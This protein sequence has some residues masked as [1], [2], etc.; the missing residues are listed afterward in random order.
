[1]FFKYYPFMLLLNHYASAG[2]DLF[3]L[4]NG[5]N[6]LNAELNNLETFVEE[7]TTQTCWINQEFDH[8]NSTEKR[9][10][11]MRYFQRLSFRK[12]NGPIYLFLGGE[13]AASPRWAQT[14]IMYELAKE[15]NGAMY[16][17][18]HRYYGESKPLNGTDAEA[19]KYLSAR[20][21]L[22]DNANFLKYLKRK[23]V[24]RKS[25]VVVIG[26]SYS[27]NLAA[28]MKLLY[29]DLVDAAIASSGPV[30]AKTDFFEYL[31][32]VN[33]NYEQHGTENC[34]GNIRKIFQRY[35]KLM[36]NPEGIEILKKEENICEECD[37]S[38]PENQQ[39]F[40][41]S[42]VGEFMQISQYGT[43]GQIKSH[44]KRIETESVCTNRSEE[45]N[46]NNCSCYDFDEMIDSF[47]EEENKWILAWLYQTCNEFGYYQTTSSEEQP[48]T[49]NIPLE[50]YT[51][52]CLKLFGPDFDEARVND[53][54]AEVNDLYGALKPNVTNVVF[55]NG[56]LDPWSTLG[57]LE[58]LSY[59][60]PAVVIPRSSHCRDL[61]SNRKGDIEELKEAR[62]HVKYLIKKWIGAES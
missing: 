23:S 52:M 41:S 61:F 49:K 19:F 45:S 59:S 31:E 16:V 54:V 20:Q 43:T 44:C 15:T 6:Y 32:K 14:G 48:F 8:F 33:D 29:P 34:L 22:A 50:F 47:Y 51:K 30:L 4:I 7:F 56:D 35:D 55:T 58:D 21:A 2:I 9:V 10:W 12:F 36:Q 24:Y 60:A 5:L 40:F 11:K 42:K 46:S 27:G 18:E 26:G 25:K 57:I 28:W 3:S 53:G 17:S 37:L 1:M 13:S 39:V 38:K 62:K